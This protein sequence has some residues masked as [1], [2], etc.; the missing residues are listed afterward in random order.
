VE[1][2]GGRIWVKRGQAA[3]ST[4]Q[5]ALTRPEQAA[6]SHLIEDGQPA[7]GRR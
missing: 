3:G 7:H 5:F 4:I 1:R 2:H 6:R